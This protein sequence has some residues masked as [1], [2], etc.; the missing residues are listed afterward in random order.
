MSTTGDERD[1]KAYSMT[2]TISATDARVHFGEVLRGVSEE[3]ATYY[4]ERSGTPVAVVIPVD[5]YETL[6][7]Q[8]GESVRPAWL[9]HVIRVGQQLAKERAGKPPINWE[10][11]ID[12]GREERDAQLLE[13][14]FGCKSDRED[15]RT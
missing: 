7:Q 1:R 10:K 6:R 2:R 5:E 13:G 4:V 8:Q 15:A 12:E 11:I 9:D 14:L 3:R